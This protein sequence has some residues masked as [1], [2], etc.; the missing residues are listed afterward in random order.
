MP[1]VYTRS[2]DPNLDCNPGST[3]LRRLTGYVTRITIRI[4]AF[5]QLGSGLRLRI[6]FVHDVQ[7]RMRTNDSLWTLNWRHYTVKKNSKLFVYYFLFRDGGT[8]I[9]FGGDACMRGWEAADYQVLV[10]KSKLEG[11]KFRRPCYSCVTILPML[12]QRM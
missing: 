5:T 3:H 7:L 10:R 2:S 11:L 4:S 6:Q 12:I 1:T 9:R 8:E